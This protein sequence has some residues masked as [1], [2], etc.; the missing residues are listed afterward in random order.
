MSKGGSRCV[1]EVFERVFVLTGIFI[2]GGYYIRVLK[3][4]ASRGS[5]GMSPQK[6]LKSRGPEMLFSAFCTSIFQTRWSV[7]QVF[8]VITT[9]FP[10]FC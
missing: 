5:G 6:N 10:V 8:L 9:I 7:K 1:A 4:R 3:V 2:M